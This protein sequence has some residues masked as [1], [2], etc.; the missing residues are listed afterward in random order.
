MIPLRTA[1]LVLA[2]AWPGLARAQTAPIPGVGN[3]NFST[4]GVFPATS[5]TVLTGPITLLQQPINSFVSYTGTPGVDGTYQYHSF[6][7]NDAV[8]HTAASNAIAGSFQ[9]KLNAGWTGSRVGLGSSVNLLGQGGATAGSVLALWGDVTGSV[10]QGGLSNTITG[11]AGSIWAGLLNATLLAPA[12]NYALFQGLEIDMNTVGTTIRRHGLQ[13][14]LGPADVNRGAIFDA[15][16]VLGNNTASA[17]TWKHGIVLGEDSA[18]WPFASDSTLI[19]AKMGQDDVTKPAVAALGLDLVDVT[20]GTAAFRTAGLSVDG[21]GNLQIGTGYLQPVSGGLTIDTKGAVGNTASGAGMI[22]SGGSGWAGG[23]VL[24]DPY[25]GRYKVSSVAAGVITALTVYRQPIFATTTTPAN[26]V[27]L[28]LRSGTTSVAPTINVSWNT[29]GNT[30][31]LQPSGGGLKVGGTGPITGFGTAIGQA[32]GPLVSSGGAGLPMLST[33][34]RLIFRRASPGISD[35]EDFQF[36]RTSAFTGGAATDINRVIGVNT[37]MGANDGTQTAGIIAIGRNNSTVFGFLP[38]FW[39]QGIRTAASNGYISAGV[40]S[41]DDQTGL[42]SAA[43][44]FPGGSGTE[45]DYASNAADDATN[46]NRFGGVGVRS[47]MRFVAGRSDATNA[48][49][50]VISTG[51]WISTSPLAFGSVGADAFVSISQA[52]GFSINTQIR[53]ALDTRGTIPPTGVTDPVAAVRMTAGQII[54]FKGGAALDSAPGN[55]LWYDPGA[56]RWKYTIAGV[57]KFSIDASGNVRA[58]GTV[59]GSTTP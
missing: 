14:S 57:D 1:A 53:S 12:T 39:S 47:I 56:S 44:A 51:L 17:G 43:A 4:L 19:T 2:L 40:F 33:G 29:S 30:L 42:N 32:L 26:P 52:I 34:N 23:E 27:T 25:G 21:T 45:F 36:D 55:Y 59:T 46:G 50:T 18:R 16:I 5:T 11:A 22:V 38:T 7:T 28:G 9:L 15:A 10:N 24:T 35:S 37:T 58:A 3:P 31:S 41:Y 6:I 48:T 54:D 8:H 49:P 13:I 20:F